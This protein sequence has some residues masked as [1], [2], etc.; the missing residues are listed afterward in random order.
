[1][2]FDNL[3]LL[4]ITDDRKWVLGDFDFQ[5]CKFLNLR[6]IWSPDCHP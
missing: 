4:I 5:F 3:G 1:L 2:N 6:L